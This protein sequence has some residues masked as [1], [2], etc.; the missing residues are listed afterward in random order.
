MNCKA[1]SLMRFP[2]IHDLWAQISCLIPSRHRPRV[3][4]LGAQRQEGANSTLSGIWPAIDLLGSQMC[5]ER[6]PFGSRRATYF[7]VVT[8]VLPAAHWE[9]TA[10]AIARGCKSL[11]L[12]LLTH[13]LLSMPSGKVGS[14]RVLSSVGHHPSDQRWEL[15]VPPLR[16]LV[17]LNILCQL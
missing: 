9:K 12:T 2:T 7:A 17:M 4:F 13:A 3:A 15:T 10:R 14:S 8:A 1:S 11:P 5:S 16:F 6:F